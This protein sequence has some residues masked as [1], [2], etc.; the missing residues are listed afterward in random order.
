[1]IRRLRLTNWRAYEELDLELGPGTTFVVAPNGIGKTS[2]VEAA[3]WALFGDH[4]PPAN[5]PVRAG[6]DRAVASVQ[7]ELPDQRILSVERAH[8]ATAPRKAPEPV[9]H[10]DGTLMPATSLDGLLRDAYGADPAFLARVAMPRPHT[11]PAALDGNG[12]RDHLCRLFGVENLIAAGTDV[13]ARLRENEKRIKAAKQGSAIDRSRLE[14]LDG[15]AAASAAAAETAAAAHARAREAVV[16]AEALA[17]ANSAAR[18][19]ETREQERQALLQAVIVEAAGLVDDPV[20]PGDLGEVLTAALAAAQAQLNAVGRALGVNEG[21]AR[22]I[23]LTRQELDTA[24]GDCPVC[25][26]P[27]DAQ[28]ASD[29]RAAHD[30]DRE[31]LA[32]EREALTA[33]EA[34]LGSKVEALGRV[35]A[36]AA[37]LP[38]QALKPELPAAES[39]RESDVEA[40]R[41]SEVEALDAFVVATAARDTSR[42]ALELARNDE[43]AHNTLVGLFAT[44]AVLRAARSTIDQTVRTFVD[45]TVGPIAAEIGPRWSA[46]FPGRGQVHVDGGGALSRPYKGQELAFESFSGGERTV[47]LVLLRLLVVQMTTKATFCWFDEPLEHLDPDARRQVASLLAGAGNSLPLKQILLTTYEQPLAERLAADSPGRVSLVAVRES[48]VGAESPP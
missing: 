6:A 12:L 21:R 30:R 22:A 18:D 41:Q 14:A 11:Q 10:V 7:V 4:A 9:V 31:A 28:T 26:R 16:Y 36:A 8:P 38:A 35:S 20:T 1:V 27:L 23:E 17:R 13:D 44:E 48:T 15:V 42:A 45:G 32:E 40:I 24:H 3:A 43:T 33:Q 25:R 46:V 34:E 2:L 29:A 5:R 39:S 19:W 47:A 37:A